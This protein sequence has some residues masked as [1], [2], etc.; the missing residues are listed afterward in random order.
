M[1]NKSFYISFLI[2]VFAII[3][4]YFKTSYNIQKNQINNKNIIRYGNN[5]KKGDTI[6]IN[7]NKEIVIDVMEDGSYITKIIK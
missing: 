6:N 2:L 5:I 1:K 3:Y 7:G 4:S